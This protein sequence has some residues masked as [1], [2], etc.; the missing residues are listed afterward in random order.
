MTP[1]IV[2]VFTMLPIGAFET[3]TIRIPFDTKEQCV[4]AAERTTRNHS[5]ATKHIKCIPEELDKPV[6]PVLK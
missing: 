4:Q 3:S 5:K 6:N 1:V 2:W